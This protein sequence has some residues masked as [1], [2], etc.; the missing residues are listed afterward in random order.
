MPYLTASTLYDYI[1]CPHKVWRDIYGPQDEKIQETNAFVE[2]LW[3][4]GVQHEEKTLSLIGEYLDLTDGTHEE[5]FERTLQAMDEG[6]E[7]IYQGVLKYENM[8]GI[9]DLL[10]KLPD[11]TYMPVDIKSGMALEGGDDEFGDDGKPKKHYAVQLCFYNDLL[12][13]LG[14]AS[15]DRGKILDIH[16]GEIVYNLKEPMGVRTPKTWWEFYEE[17]KQ[18]VEFL[19]KDQYPK[20]PMK[21]SICKMCPWY[22]SCKKWCEEKDDL[23]NIFYVGRSDRDR[24]NE[25]LNVDTL[26]ELLELDVDEV[27]TLKAQE[28]KSGNKDFLYRIGQSNS[29]KAIR[30]ARLYHIEKKAVLLKPIEFPKVTYELFFDIEDDHTQ[31]FVY[32]HGVYEKHGGNVRFLEFL[33]TE[34]TDSAEKEA[35][36]KFWDYIRTLPQ[37][38]MAVYYFAHHE[39]TTY[40]RMQKKYPD[41]ISADEV[42]EFFDRPTVFDLYKVV[43]QH[44]DWPL[45]SYSLKAIAVYLGFEWRD[46]SP[47]GAL[48][49]Q[50]FN[51]YLEKRDPA[52]L[53]RIL[54]Y[55]EDDC[56]ATMVVKEGIEKLNN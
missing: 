31:E 8:L 48:S 43:Q 19:M 20:K 16:G 9:P 17:T 32:L 5:R 55:N 45:S 40:K 13:K 49:I 6:V 11:G 35:W 46:D 52:M 50:W 25:D 23:T 34:V 30:R 42:V 21:A 41:V 54:E 51:E 39:K 28:K 1:K 24:L 18:H 38:D 56:I 12:K 33:A 14:F 53:K 44:T 10:R 3:N 37:D 4:R 29:E 15:H 22:S 27:M 26:D 7:L 36:Q 47:S 2:L